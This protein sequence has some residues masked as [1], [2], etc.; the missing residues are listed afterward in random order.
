M[1][2]GSKDKATVSVEDAVADGRYVEPEYDGESG[3]E[4]NVIVWLAFTTGIDCFTGVAA[5]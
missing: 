5:P 4:V 2:A 1:L 3:V